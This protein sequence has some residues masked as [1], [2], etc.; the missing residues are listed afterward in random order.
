MTEPLQLHDIQG[1]IVRGYAG[2]GHAS[3]LLWS[4]EEPAP[5]RALLSSW[6]DR[7]TAGHESPR[8]SA[9]NIALTVDGVLQLTERDAVPVGFSHAFTSGMTSPYRSRLLGD[10]GEDAPA[11][12]RWGGP[13]TPRVDVV[14]LLYAESATGLQQLV[15]TVG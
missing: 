4:I 11:G 6:T 7:V 13:D 15:A 5:A 12:W 3:F 1:L 10:V 9:M 8:H 2:L 14:V